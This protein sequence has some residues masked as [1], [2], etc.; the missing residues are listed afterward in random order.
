MI[1]MMLANPEARKG[2]SKVFKYLLIFGGLGAGVLLFI[3]LIKK[4]NPFKAI[5]NFFGSA[6]KNVGGFFGNIFSGIAGA[7][8]GLF[9]GFGV[10][11]PNYKRKKI[12]YEKL[13]KKMDS[14]MKMVKKQDVLRRK[15]MLKL[16]D[17]YGKNFGAGFGL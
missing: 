6:A 10:N 7:V 1:P 8:G 11:D 14:R 16:Q 3:L 4:L 9:G 5:G 2:M 12:A 13:R 15:G 17:K